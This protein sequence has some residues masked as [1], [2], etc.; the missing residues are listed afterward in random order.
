MQALNAGFYTDESAYQGYRTFVNLIMTMG[1][2]GAVPVLSDS[3]VYYGVA[4]VALTSTS[5]YTVTFIGSPKTLLNM[6]GTIQQ[7]SYSKTGAVRFELTGFD[8]SAG[9]VTL[10]A[11][12]A[13]GDAT[14]PTTGDIARLTF[15]IQRSPN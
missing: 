5:T 2:S 8:S 1:S 11:V 4:S 3:G 6:V 9:T 15:E 7:A 14:A 13:A 12:D 10:L